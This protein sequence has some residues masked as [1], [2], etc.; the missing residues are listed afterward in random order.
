MLRLVA[1][2]PPNAEIAERLCIGAATVETYVSRLLTKLDAARVHLVIHAYES[3]LV[4]PGG[5]RRLG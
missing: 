5:E 1:Q 2:G 3:G 4:T